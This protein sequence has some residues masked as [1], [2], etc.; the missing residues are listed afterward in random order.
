M[1]IFNNIFKNIFKDN[2]KKNTINNNNLKDNLKG[3]LKD[4]VNINIVNIKY[5]VEQLDKLF[6][7]IQIKPETSINSV[8]YNEGQRSIIDFLKSKENL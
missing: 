7:K 4:T 2:S 6:P 8:M 1:N 5:T 3:N